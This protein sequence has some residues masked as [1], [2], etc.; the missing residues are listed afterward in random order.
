[1]NVRIMPK[2]STS[3][4]AFNVLLFE[5]QDAKSPSRNVFSIFA[6][7]RRSVFAF[8]IGKLRTFIKI[9]LQGGTTCAQAGAKHA[10]VL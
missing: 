1:M 9:I 6:P 3:L 8:K 2:Y 10:A 5:R 7:L 4:S